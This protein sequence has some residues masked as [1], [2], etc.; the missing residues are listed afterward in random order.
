MASSDNKNDNNGNNG[1]HNTSTITNIILAEYFSYLYKIQRCVCYY[2]CNTY[3]DYKEIIE[4]IGKCYEE[5]K[6]NKKSFKTCLKIYCNDV[7]WPYRNTFYITLD[8]NNQKQPEICITVQVDQT[9]PIETLKQ[10]FMEQI[11]LMNF[12]GDFPSLLPTRH[13]YSYI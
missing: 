11:E 8:K 5:A 6:K 12:V 2:K 9:F 4:S 7:R 13:Q 3:K 10:L 1:N